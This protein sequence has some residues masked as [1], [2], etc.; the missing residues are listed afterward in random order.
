MAQ[1]MAERCVSCGAE[2][3]DNYCP[4][5]GERRITAADRSIAAFL[6]RA[7]EEV[8]DVDSRLFRTLRRLVFSPGHLTRAFSE[9][10]RKPYLGPVQLFLLA[11]LA[12]FLVQPLS[13]YTAYNTPLKSQLN[14]QAYSEQLPVADWVE[15]ATERTGLDEDTFETV[16]NNQSELLARTLVFVMVPVFAVF[17]AVLMLGRG[18]PFVDHLVFSLHYFAFDLLVMHCAVLMVWPYLVHG[19][20]DLVTGGGPPSDWLQWAT[21]FAKELG[22]SLLVTVPWLYFAY[23]RFYGLSNWRAMPTALFSPIVL[24]MTVLTYRLLLL[25]I[26]LASV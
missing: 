4:E 20:G 8:S 13:T 16:F 7:F 24:L 9:G 18:R 11:N 5:C 25:I 21:R 12:Y 17:L 19:V 26:T 3:R 2:Q 15:T 23:R 6:R 14:R 1:A 10:R 22:A